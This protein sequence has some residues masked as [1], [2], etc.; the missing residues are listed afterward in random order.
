[1]NFKTHK[2]YALLPPYHDGPY[3]GVIRYSLGEMRAGVTGPMP[4]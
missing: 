4:V 3:K 2:Q 1:L